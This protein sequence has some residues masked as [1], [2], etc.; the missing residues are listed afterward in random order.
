MFQW[1]FVISLR[2]L[3]IFIDFRL[4]PQAAQGRPAQ[5]EPSQLQTGRSHHRPQAPPRV[6]RV[7]LHNKKAVSMRADTHFGTPGL[8]LINIHGI[9]VSK[10]SRK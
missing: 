3:Q 9:W 1:K 2:K 10:Y 5:P 6:M 7:T 4:L 8:T